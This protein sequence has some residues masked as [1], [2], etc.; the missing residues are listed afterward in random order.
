[1]QQGF[2]F[3]NAVNRDSF[4]GIGP[5]FCRYNLTGVTRKWHKPAGDA[6]PF[7]YL[8]VSEEVSVDADGHQLR[9][10][11]QGDY[12]RSGNEKV[13]F[14]TEQGNPRKGLLDG[15]GELTDGDDPKYVERQTYPELAF[16]GLKLPQRW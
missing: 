16:A 5:G 8:V 9:V 4:W 15:G 14:L 12:Y 11:D 1:M 6:P 2:K 13:D 3:Q 7:P 10:L